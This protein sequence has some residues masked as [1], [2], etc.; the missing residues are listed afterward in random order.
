[1]SGLG[2]TGS[3]GGDRGQAH[4]SRGGLPTGAAAGPVVRTATAT[5]SGDR[6]SAPPTVPGCSGPPPARTGSRRWPRRDP[7]GSSE[8]PYDGCSR[9]ATPTRCWLPAVGGAGP[10]TPRNRIGRPPVRRAPPVRPG[11]VAATART[12]GPMGEPGQEGACRRGAAAGFLVEGQR[13]GVG[14]AE[15]RSMSARKRRRRHP[16]HLPKAV[17]PGARPASAA[18]GGE[19]TIGQ[20]ACHR[21]DLVDD[22][23]ATTRSTDAS[24]WSRGGWRP[25]H[26]AWWRGP[27][28][29][30]NGGVGCDRSTGRRRRSRSAAS[31]PPAPVEHLWRAMVNT[32]PGGRFVAPE[33]ADATHHRHPG[34]GRQVLGGG[35]CG[36]RE[37]PQQ[38]GLEVV[39]EPPERLLV[40]ADGGD[41]HGRE[42]GANHRHPPEGPV[43]EA[44]K[45]HVA[46]Q[47]C[48]TRRPPPIP[49]RVL[50]NGDPAPA[51]PHG[52]AAPPASLP[53]PYCPARERTIGLA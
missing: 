51:R 38:P 13:V 37:V 10:F 30:P 46:P 44:N 23:P 3:G 21:A 11:Q 2:P 31:R 24:A 7:T 14:V 27:P 45:L 5:D 32:R 28:R 53:E 50:R 29:R 17:A 49:K 22:E 33:A 9:T 8:P 41:K 18:P 6:R 48:Q 43:P 26:A 15:G 42:L 35:G 40:T 47:S 39:P 4:R 12:R 1:M 52:F 19:N 16:L 25:G 36:H 20:G 34:L